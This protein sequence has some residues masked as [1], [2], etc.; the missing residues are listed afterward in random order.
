MRTTGAKPKLALVGKFAGEV[1]LVGEV[2][3][4]V[5]LVRET[6]IATSKNLQTQ[7]IDIQSYYSP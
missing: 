3:R 7:D 6:V 1:R 2:A 4:Q 5:V